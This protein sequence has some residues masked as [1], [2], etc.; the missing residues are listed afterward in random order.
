MEYDVVR[1]SVINAY[2]SYKST[3]KEKFNRSMQ[4]YYTV[5]QQNHSVAHM[6]MVDQIHKEGL[7]QSKI[8]HRNYEIY[9]K[10]SKVDTELL[11]P[12]IDK[13]P[14]IERQVKRDNAILDTL[15]GV[16][17]FIC[18]SETLMTDEISD[19]VKLSKS[20]FDRTYRTMYP[21]TYHIR[22]RLIEDFGFSM[23]KITPKRPYHEKIQLAA[24]EQGWKSV[25]PNSYEN[26]VRLLSM[27]RIGK[28]RRVNLLKKKF[29]NLSIVKNY[30]LKK[31]MLKML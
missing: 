15:M 19:E 26:R 7:K 24:P 8:N 3:D 5:G 23:D 14:V 9:K 25:Y 16:K 27:D 21:K 31:A 6:I 30:D 29:W 1:N 11:I 10:N 2:Q 17:K 13:T 28:S 20:A 22:K 4:T 18:A 12:M